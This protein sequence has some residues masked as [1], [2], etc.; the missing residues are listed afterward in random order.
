MAAKAEM[1]YRVGG[2]LLMVSAADGTDVRSLL[3]SYE[4]FGME[5]SLIHL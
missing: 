1:R 3:P 5:L 4:R 2:H